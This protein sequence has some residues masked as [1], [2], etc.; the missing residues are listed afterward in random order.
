MVESPIAPV[1]QTGLN[2]TGQVIYSDDT[3]GM[4][5]G[6]QESLHERNKWHQNP[7]SHWLADSPLPL[8]PSSFDTRRS[9]HSCITRRVRLPPPRPALPR[10]MQTSSEACIIDGK[11]EFELRSKVRRCS[12]SNLAARRCAAHHHPNRQDPLRTRRTSA[13]A[14][15]EILITRVRCAACRIATVVC[16]WRE[17]VKGFFGWK[18]GVEWTVGFVGLAKAWHDVT[19]HVTTGIRMDACKHCLCLRDLI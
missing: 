12:A 13:V 6:K 9:P 15:A 8:V 11:T 5:K 19:G 7:C 18:G 10:K 3:Q 17:W 4:C 2:H 14:K 1:P 16:C